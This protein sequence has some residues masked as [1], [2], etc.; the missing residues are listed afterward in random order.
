M[1]NRVV[2]IGIIGTG[3]IAQAHIRRLMQIP[4][5]RIVALCD[6][7]E[8]KVRAVAG[9]PD[10]PTFTDGARLIAETEL[11]ALY[12]CVPPDQHGDM[13]IQAARKGIHL[14]VEKPVNRSLERA[15]EIAAVIR[16]TGVM[17]QSGYVF[18]YLAST[19]QLKTFLQDKPV[20]TANVIRWCGIPGMPWWPY[21]DQSGGQLFEMTTHQ[22]DLLRW[23]M[24]EVEAVSASY[25]F[26]RLLPD[27]PEMTVPDTQTALLHFRSGASATVSTSCALGKGYRGEAEFLIR[28]ARVSW[29]A[30]GLKV[31]PEGVYTLAP[32]PEETPSIDAAFV[33]AVAS[34]N[35]VFLRSPYDDALRTV[36]VTLA[37]NRSAEEGG[38]L[39]RIEEMLGASETEESW[40]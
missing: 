5:A 28:D 1:S 37:A 11:D 15:K 21:Y 32:A 38:R 10:A 19:M 9:P 40:K 7:I 14:F 24:G 35:P 23:V 22:V 18:R 13:E 30:D 25:S 29:R 33:R 36:A 6:I 16:E 17:S 26:H 39:V 34:D 20:G 12:L 27:R 4:E 3:G 8:D 31:E 2:R